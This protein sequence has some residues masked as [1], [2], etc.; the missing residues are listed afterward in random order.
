M[1]KGLLSALACYGLWGILPIYW[2]SIQHIPSDQILAHRMLWSLVFVSLFLFST[3]GFRWIKT[4]LKNTRDNVFLLGASLLITF[5]WFIYIWAVNSN[6]IVETSLGYFI[7]PLVSF[8]FG[9]FIFGER[10]SPV[11]WFAILLASS[12][13]LY[14]TW[15][16]GQWPWIALTL[17]FTF[18]AYSA[19]KKTIKIHPIHGMFIETAIVFLPATLYLLYKQNNGIGAL[20]NVSLKTDLL[21]IFAGLFT[22][23]PLYYFASAVQRIPLTTLGT[24]QY[25][26]P[27]LQFLV[28][29]FIYQE[30]FSGSDLFGY[31]M[32]WC[33]LLIFS[34]ERF[35]LKYS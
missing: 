16:Y 10:P 30:A 19:L 23:L 12:G 11:K 34:C 14:L 32:I 4:A 18:A 24:L 6:H 7:S 26:A 25:L 22:F 21:L 29:V 17:A 1:N 33:A 15:S 9:V 2:K 3:Q 20:G 13:V 27:T 35:L 8:L 5:N 31:S 28:G